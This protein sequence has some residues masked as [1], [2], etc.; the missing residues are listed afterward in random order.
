MSLAMRFVLL[1]ALARLLYSTRR[2]GSQT[3]RSAQAPVATPRHRRNYSFFYS[4]LIR[5][6]LSGLFMP[7][8][9][10]ERLYLEERQVI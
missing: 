9:K 3:L 6:P 4:Q 5:R 7:K 8:N 2:R 1:F 10:S